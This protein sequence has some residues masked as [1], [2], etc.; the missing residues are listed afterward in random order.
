MVM[1]PY[2]FEHCFSIQLIDLPKATHH[3]GWPKSREVFSHFSNGKISYN[4]NY[5]RALT[6]PYSLGIQATKWPQVLLRPIR[7]RDVPMNA[8]YRNSLQ[9]TTVRNIIGKHAGTHIDENLGLVGHSC[10]VSKRPD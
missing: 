6:F 7:R 8:D 10:D 3:D 5:D 2:S 1:S 9:K 4:G